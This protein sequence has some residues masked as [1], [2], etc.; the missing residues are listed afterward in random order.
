MVGTEP[1]VPL[2]Y[3]ELMGLL[4]NGEGFI[5]ATV[6]VTNCQL[7]YPDKA[8]M[9]TTSKTSRPELK[10]YVREVFFVLF[11]SINYSILLQLLMSWVANPFD[12]GL[13]PCSTM[14]KT[15]S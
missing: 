3:P 1:L 13:E 14:N 9:F 6:D 4:S 2:T 10:P 12:C 11:Q 15:Q 5:T 8:D 7:V